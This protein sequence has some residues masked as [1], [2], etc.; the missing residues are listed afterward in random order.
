VQINTHLCYPMWKLSI[1]Q[2]KM[3]KAEKIYLF[4]PK[5]IKPLPTVMSY[6][7]NCLAGLGGPDFKAVRR[8]EP[9]SL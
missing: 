3:G 4:S 5:E 1:C 6:A 9:E 2:P 8:N 7:A